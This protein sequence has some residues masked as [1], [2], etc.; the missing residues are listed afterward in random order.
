MVTVFCA[1]V[2]VPGSVF[3]VKIDENESVAEL[4]K[5]IKKENP[6]IFQCNAMDCLSDEGGRRVADGGSCEGRLERHQW[7]EAVGFNEGETKS[8]GVEERKR[9]RRR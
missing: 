5:A 7:V 2:G 3:S 6:N 4:K 8:S 9:R 1:I